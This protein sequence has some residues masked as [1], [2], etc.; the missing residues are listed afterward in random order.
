MSEAR[1][2][3]NMI[4]NGIACIVVGHWVKEVDNVRLHQVLSSAEEVSLPE[5][6][7]EVEEKIE[8]MEDKVFKDLEGKLQPIPLEVSREN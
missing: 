2:I 8:E 5:P 1:S 6:I 4:G 3:T 7:V